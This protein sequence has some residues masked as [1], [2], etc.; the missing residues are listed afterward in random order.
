MI[1]VVLVLLGGTSGYYIGNEVQKYGRK[2]KWS[3]ARIFTVTCILS[4]IA[5]LV[6]AR[7]AAE[8]QLI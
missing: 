6:L 5:G 8:T 2:N 4:T 3:D 7:L 1:L